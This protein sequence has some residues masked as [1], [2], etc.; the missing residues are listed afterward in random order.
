MHLKH[1]TWNIIPLHHMLYS[2]NIHL[3]NSCIYIQGH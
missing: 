3:I 2:P 1:S